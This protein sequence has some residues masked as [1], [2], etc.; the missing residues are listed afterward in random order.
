MITF[1]SLVLKYDYSFFRPK[2]Q[3]LVPFLGNLAVFFDS[4]CF[5][6]RQVISYHS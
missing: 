4:I 3:L 6:S 2:A 5:D 1:V